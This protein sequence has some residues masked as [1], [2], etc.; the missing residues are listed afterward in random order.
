MLNYINITKKLADSE[1]ITQENDICLLCL[2]DTNEKLCIINTNCGSKCKVLMHKEC[3]N[4]ILS[5]GLQCP[6]CRIRTKNNQTIHSF[7][8]DPILLNFPIYLFARYP[9][10]LTFGFFVFFSFAVTFLFILPML[11]YYGLKERQFKNNIISTLMLLSCF[12]MYLGNYF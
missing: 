9:N 7:E 11:I 3:Y 8:S 4:K 5:N 6:I 12:V 1:Y 10:V 2:D